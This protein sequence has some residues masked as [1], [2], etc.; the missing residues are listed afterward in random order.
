MP[1]KTRNKNAQEGASRRMARAMLR[2]IPLG[3]L[4]VYL[5]V[6][7][8]GLLRGRDTV[9]D[10]N[11]SVCGA[12][13]DAKGGACGAWCAFPGVIPAGCFDQ[14][15]QAELTKADFHAAIENPASLRQAL[16]EEL[17]QISR[18]TAGAKLHLGPKVDARAWVLRP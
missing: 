18:A 7:D 17:V 9:A 12:G 6:L 4:E 16:G 13:C 3:Q 8:S 15:G 5:Q 11:G 1:T 14:W 2:E 10:D